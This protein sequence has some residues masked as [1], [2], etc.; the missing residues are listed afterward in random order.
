MQSHFQF[1][2][3]TTVSE[4]SSGHIKG[5]RV[6]ETVHKSADIIMHYYT[7]NY[8]N[9]HGFSEDITDQ[10]AWLAKINYIIY[11]TA[12]YE[13]VSDK[14]NKLYYD[15]LINLKDSRGLETDLIS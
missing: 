10:L 11:I 4:T 13:K 5:W 7:I 12:L 1:H 8:C 3:F 14:N 6:K 9:E 15:I 2:D